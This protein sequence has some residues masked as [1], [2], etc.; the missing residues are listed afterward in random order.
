MRIASF[1]QG[2]E[3]MWI[4]SMVLEMAFNLETVIWGN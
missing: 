2:D 1:K 3:A 4:L